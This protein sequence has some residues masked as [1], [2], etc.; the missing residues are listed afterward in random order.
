ML[1]LGVALTSLAETHAPGEVAATILHAGVPAADIAR[2]ER[3]VA[4]RVQ[5]TW[6]RVAESEVAGAH[7]STFLTPASLFRLLLPQFL[8][9]GLERVIY[10]DCDTVIAGSLRPLW[11]LDLGHHLVAAA[12]DAGAP[13][14][15][16][17]CGTD[18]QGL[19]LAPG[20]PYLNTGVLVIPLASWRANDVSRRVLEVLRASQPRWGDQDGLNVVMQ[21]RWLELPRRW[22]LQTSDVDGRGLAWALWRQDVDAALA[23]PA[24]VHYTERDKPWMPGSRHPLAERWFA[25]LDASAW[26]GW[27][28]DRRSRPLVRRVG[29]RVKAA[30]RILT[31]KPAGVAA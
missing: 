24:I 23:D 7:Y 9:A 10:L 2:V 21:G 26:C 18:W 4:G 25:A 17:P 11:E 8:P 29:S 15:A 30:W 22:N 1:P 31:A 20:A 16:G 6:R 13:F 12:R 27:R 28:P 14:P 5:L 3:S 19:G